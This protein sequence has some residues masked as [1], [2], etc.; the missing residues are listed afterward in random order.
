M[1]DRSDIHIGQRVYDRNQHRA[2]IILAIHKPA[3]PNFEPTEALVEVDRNAVSWVD[4]E[5][6][7]AAA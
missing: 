1:M 7:E 6:L 5:S 3:N 2:G 4:F